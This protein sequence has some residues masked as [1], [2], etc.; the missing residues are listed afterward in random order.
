MASPV[1]RGGA[2]AGKSRF[3]INLDEAP[4]G[5]GGGFRSG[6]RRGG[7]RSGCLKLSG[8][9]AVVL[10]GILLAALAGG[11]YWWRGYQQR[12]AYTLALL[13]DAAQ[14][15]DAQAIEQYADLDRISSSFI[16]QVITEARR[17]FNAP[18]GVENLA[19]GQYEDAVTRL[20]PGLR[21]NVR[22]E[23]MRQA[24]EAGARAANVPFIVIALAVPY[25]VD[26]V[27]EEGNNATVALKIGERNVELTMER[28]NDRWK[29]VG[30]RDEALAARIVNDAME[31]TGGANAGLTRDLLRNIPG[32]NPGGGRG[33]GNQNRRRETPRIPDNLNLSDILRPNQDGNNEGNNSNEH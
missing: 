26:S 19:R 5:G 11:Y 32:L 1:E 22:D 31:R 28:N 9:V 3:V 14:R 21:Q 13:V 33:R 4:P 10:I 17:R 25:V 24:R 12:P 18:E 2:P 16:P 30:A 8:I 20:T 23:V 6:G 27:R 15:D 7:G 29:I